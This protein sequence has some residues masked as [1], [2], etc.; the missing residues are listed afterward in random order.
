MFGGRLAS[1]IGGPALWEAAGPAGDHME[2]IGGGG[3]GQGIGS[4]GSRPQ[5]IRQPWRTTAAHTITTNVTPPSLAPPVQN[6][7]CLVHMS[8]CRYGSRFYNLQQLLLEFGSG[9]TEVVHCTGNR[10]WRG[11]HSD[12][13]TDAGASCCCDDIVPPIC[14]PRTM[15]A[16][17]SASTDQQAAATASFIGQDKAAWGTVKSSRA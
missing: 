13:L 2:E 3:S 15:C 7:R 5:H 17:H 8:G 10:R 11:T 6:E 14:L 1:V 9:S 4:G 12:T 16:V